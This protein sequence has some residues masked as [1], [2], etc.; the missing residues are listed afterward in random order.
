[1]HSGAQ[2]RVFSLSPL[3]LCHEAAAASPRSSAGEQSNAA[4]AAA[5]RLPEF[6]YETLIYVCVCLP[7]AVPNAPLG[8][9]LQVEAVPKQYESLPLLPIL[10]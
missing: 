1:M 3:P 9:A 6:S 10:Y 5:K 8:K 7:L 4:A 2:K